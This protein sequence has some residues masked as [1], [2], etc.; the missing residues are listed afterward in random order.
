MSKSEKMKNFL[1]KLFQWFQTQ[2]QIKQDEILEG[3]IVI[4]NAQLR[5][6]KKNIIQLFKELVDNNIIEQE[7][8]LVTKTGNETTILVQNITLSHLT[9]RLKFIQINEKYKG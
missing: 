6:V 8:K 3:E 7:L 4:P 5:K 9:A 1:R 2:E